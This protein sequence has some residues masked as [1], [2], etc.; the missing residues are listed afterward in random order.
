MTYPV[1]EKV[2]VSKHG[3]SAFN[4]IGILTLMF[5]GFVLALVYSVSDVHHEW[6]EYALSVVLVCAGVVWLWF[7]AKIDRKARPASR[8]APKNASHL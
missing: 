4:A 6:Y 5:S 7:T 1:K 8:Y 3:A 2:A